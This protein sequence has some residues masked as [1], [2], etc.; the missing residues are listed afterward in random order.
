MYNYLQTTTQP[1]EPIL[2]QAKEKAKINE[3]RKRKWKG[4]RMQSFDQEVSQEVLIG[5]NTAPL[6]RS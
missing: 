5:H 2:S 6:S 3:A 1:T 4:L